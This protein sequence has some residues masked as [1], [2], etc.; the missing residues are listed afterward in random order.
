MP[1]M[2]RKRSSDGRRS[3]IHGWSSGRV[4]RQIQASFWNESPVASR[5]G[6]HTVK[7]RC[8]TKG[9]RV[10]THMF[11]IAQSTQELAIWK[12]ADCEATA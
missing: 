7:T 5:T 2:H 6:Y 10:G 11:L 9:F 3:R 1:S 12:G 4:H 8:K